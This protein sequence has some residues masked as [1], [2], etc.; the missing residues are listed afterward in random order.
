MFGRQNKDV[1]LQQ[2]DDCRAFAFEDWHFI[3]AAQIWNWNITKDFLN[4]SSV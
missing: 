4:I 1:F 2:W 3:V